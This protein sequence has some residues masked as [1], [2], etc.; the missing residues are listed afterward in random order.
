M[1][2]GCGNKIKLNE[3]F[4][5]RKLGCS[6]YFSWAAERRDIEILKLLKK[7]GVN[8]NIKGNKGNTL[9]HMVVRKQDALD[10]AQILI[11]CGANVNCENDLKCK[12]FDYARS[13]EM[14]KLLLENGA[15]ISWYQQLECLF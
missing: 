12:P 7:V 3:L 15:Q 1:R 13:N 2:I 10:I 6:T 14:K 5:V 4:S 9:L 11:A 8:P